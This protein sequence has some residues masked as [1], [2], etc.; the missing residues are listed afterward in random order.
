MITVWSCASCDHWRHKRWEEIDWITSP[1]CEQ[2]GARM[3]SALR[4]RPTRSAPKVANFARNGSTLVR[5]A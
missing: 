4:S 3:Q 1:R 2:C 5:V